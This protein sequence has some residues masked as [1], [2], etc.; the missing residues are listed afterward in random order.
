MITPMNN[1]ASLVLSARSIL[2]ICLSLLA[3]CAVATAVSSSAQNSIGPNPTPSY[4]SID[5]SLALDPFSPSETAYIFGG[6][7]VPIGFSY[8]PGA[9]VWQKQMFGGGPLDQYQEVDVVE[10]VKVG[11]GSA[12]T[13]WHETFVTPS[14]VCSTDA[15]DSFYTINGGPV[16]TTGISYSPDD[17]VLNIDFPTDEPAGTV[18][19][20]HQEMQYMGADTFDNDG[21]AIVVNQC[22]T[23]PEPCTLALLGL[24]AGI[25]FISRRR[26]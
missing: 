26:K 17:T 14:F 22:A 11:A 18:I 8:D 6:P 3:V 25:G 15:D 13:D 5:Y 7:S 21:N 20:L 24:G 1:Q 2:R 23:V 16:Q 10:Y 9:G 12:W 4:T 19:A